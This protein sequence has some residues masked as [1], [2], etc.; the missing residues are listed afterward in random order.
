MNRAIKSLALFFVFVV[1][2]IASRHAIHSGTTT[3]LSSTSTSSTTSTSTLN[4]CQGS[5]FTGV[6]DGGEG[7]AG[8][9]FDAVTL[10]KTTA[11][12]CH[13]TGYPL[14]TMQDM[15]GATVTLTVTHNSPTTGYNFPTPGANTAPVALTLSKGSTVSFSY[16]F[17]DVGTSC[18]AAK[19]LNVQTTAAG[20][21]TPVTLQYNQSLCG[22]AL[23]V[24]PF[25]AG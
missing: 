22:G 9:V 11:G 5:D 8:T 16:A 20:S 1:V 23:T 6:D 24:S 15:Q 3:T 7:A 19:T 25:Y 21:S 12:T 17:S 10:T 14:V 2:V 4:Q 18:P 13:L